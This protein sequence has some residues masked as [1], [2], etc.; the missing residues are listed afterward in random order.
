MTERTYRDTWRYKKKLEARCPEGWHKE[1]K[2]AHPIHCSKNGEQVGKRRVREEVIGKKIMES[3]KK[4]ASNPKR[5]V[6]YFQYA[7]TD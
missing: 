6:L 2:L 1:E 3:I 5:W 4:G 7:E